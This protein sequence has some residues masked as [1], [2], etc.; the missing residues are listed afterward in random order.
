MRLLV[1]HPESHVSAQLKEGPNRGVLLRWCQQ[2]PIVEVKEKTYTA[3]VH[4]D[5]HWSY[6]VCEHLRGRQEAETESAE[7]KT[8]PLP[9]KAEE[10]VAPRMHRH[11]Y[12]AL[13]S[14]VAI[15]LC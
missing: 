14:I 12:A 13:R 4:S 5:G 11:K 6:Y 15:Q 3:L 10:L 8:A 1:V 2:Q 9:H 7:L